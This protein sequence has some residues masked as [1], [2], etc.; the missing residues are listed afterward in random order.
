MGD[1]IAVGVSQYRP[2]CASYSQSG[3]TSAG[4]IK[5]WGDKPEAAKIVVISLG[6]NDYTVDTMTHIKM[7]RNNITAD[8]VI[9]LLPR[10]DRVPMA[11]NAVYEVARQFNDV[12]VDRPKEVSPDGIHPTAAGYKWLA[13]RTR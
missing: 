11:V 6:A 4:W 1:S 2:E 5:K 10:A 7:L 8:K 13:D 12:I 9:W 3:I